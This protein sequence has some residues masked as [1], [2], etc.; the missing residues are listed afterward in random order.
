M[1][2]RNYRGGI[3]RTAKG[4]LLE[5]HE[6]DDGYDYTLSDRNNKEIDGGVLEG[7]EWLSEDFVLY[8]ALSL[9]DHED[10]FD[11]LMTLIIW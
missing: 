11:G 6:C 8:E 5:V 9:I 7:D 4:N 2:K 10:E 3:Y 1:H